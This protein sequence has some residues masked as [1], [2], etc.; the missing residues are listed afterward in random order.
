LKHFFVPWIWMR[1][2]VASLKHYT[3]ERGG[4]V[5][6]SP[7]DS[8]S[9]ALIKSHSCPLIVDDQLSCIL[10]VEPACPHAMCDLSRIMFTVLRVVTYLK[11][12]AVRE[13]SVVFTRTP[14]VGWESERLKRGLCLTGVFVKLAKP[15]PCSTA[16]TRPMHAFSDN[17]LQIKEDGSLHPIHAPVLIH[18]TGVVDATLLTNACRLRHISHHSPPPLS[19]LALST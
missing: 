15:H 14:A 1:M 17:T 10:S 7:W 13:R 11:Q 16:I 2:I 5:I 12:Y 9:L 19:S 18:P 8:W 4:G 3:D 6:N